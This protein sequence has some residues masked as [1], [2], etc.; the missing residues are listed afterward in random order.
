MFRVFLALSNGGGVK[1]IHQSVYL[2]VNFLY[3]Q[4]Y[5]KDVDEDHKEN[6]LIFKDLTLMEMRESVGLKKKKFSS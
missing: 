4:N 5:L 6:A 3:I 2:S 1:G